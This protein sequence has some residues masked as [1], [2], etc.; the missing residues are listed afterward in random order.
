VQGDQVTAT[1][2]PAERPDALLSLDGDAYVRLGWGRLDLAAEIA[3]GRVRV[4]GDQTRA[5]ALQRLFSDA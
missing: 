2:G 5:L 1:P 3:R 4:E